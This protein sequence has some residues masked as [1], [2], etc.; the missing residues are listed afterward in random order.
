M[1]E[2]DKEPDAGRVRQFA[3][4]FKNYM[5]ISSIVTAALPI[6]I[7]AVGLIPIYSAQKPFLSVY[8]SLFCFLILGFLFFIRHSL[9]QRMF[10]RL[11][12]IDL[13]WSKIDQKEWRTTSMPR[14]RVVRLRLKYALYNFLLLIRRNFVPTLPFILILLAFVSTLVYHD[15]LNQ[16][17]SELGGTEEVLS[18]TPLNRI[19]YSTTL[20]L[21]YLGIFIAAE[22]AFIL[23][24]IKE[25]IQDLVGI[26]DIEIMTRYEYK[27]KEALRA[28]MEKEGSSFL[29]EL[30]G[31]SH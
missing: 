13:H 24:A 15:H 29:K 20:T 23:M 1:P 11:L 10:P 28:A 26:T 3:I 31:R 27:D 17:I 14:I 6:P 30:K 22:A 16:S 5:S 21:T 2:K 12:G 8:T 18:Q 9:A 4:F 19:P 7:T 25:Y